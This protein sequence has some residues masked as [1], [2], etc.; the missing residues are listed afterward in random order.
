MNQTDG[1]MPISSAP[2]D[3]T[4]FQAWVHRPDT[5]LSPG[6]WEPRCRFNPD[7]EAFEI[8][9]RVDYDCDGWDTYLHLEPT[10]WMPEPFPPRWDVLP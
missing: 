4:S 2:R 8:W 5:D 1:W 7:S 9:G 6:G 3:G 10:H